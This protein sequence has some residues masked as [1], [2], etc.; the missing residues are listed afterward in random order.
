MPGRSVE[1]NEKEGIM[2]HPALAVV[3]ALTL[4][5]AARADVVKPTWTRVC[6]RVPFISFSIDWKTYPVELSAEQIKRAPRWDPESGDA[7]PLSFGAAQR[8]AWAELVRTVP[9]P[10]QWALQN[11]AIDAL[12][13]GQAIYEVTWRE[14]SSK[15]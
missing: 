10:E 5:T 13:D 11:I 2:R 1:S 15:K 9:N 3:T 12:C 4:A 14:R 6:T 8:L 7:L